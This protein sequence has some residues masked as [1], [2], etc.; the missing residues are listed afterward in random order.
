[1]LHEVLKHLRHVGLVT[2]AVPIE[3][4]QVV[5]RLGLLDLGRGL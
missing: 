3:L 1:M 5:K 4:E 2:L